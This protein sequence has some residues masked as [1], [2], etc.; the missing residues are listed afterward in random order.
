MAGKNAIGIEFS[1]GDVFVRDAGEHLSCAK[2]SRMGILTALAPRNAP[3]IDIVA[4]V[5]GKVMLIQVKSSAREKNIQWGVSKKP[6]DR[7]NFYFIFV[8]WE[9][10]NM[11]E[12]FI[13]PS[14]IVNR[15]WTKSNKNPGYVNKS[16]IKIFSGQWEL[17][18][19]FF[20]G[21]KVSY[22]KHNF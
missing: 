13:V 5:N 8:N 18:V 10:N 14:K 1:S 7:E 19:E 21:K 9:D 12:F 20:W 6:E 11:P 4:V 15:V 3:E 17:I 2:L 16:D 22:Y